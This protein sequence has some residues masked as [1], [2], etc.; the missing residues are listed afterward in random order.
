MAIARALVHEPD[1]L[2]ADEPTGN[3][4][5]ETGKT[6]FTLLQEMNRKKV[7]VLFLS[8]MT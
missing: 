4:D 8:P 5:T 2:L 7:V 1:W 3:L 6:I